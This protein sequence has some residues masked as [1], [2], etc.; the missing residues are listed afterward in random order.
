MPDG[1]PQLCPPVLLVGMLENRIP[2]GPWGM[3]AHSRAW[4][5]AG[6]GFQRSVGGKEGKGGCKLGEKVRHAINMWHPRKEMSVCGSI[7]TPVPEMG[8]EMVVIW[9][10]KSGR[11]GTR[12]TAEGGGLPEFG[13]S[14]HGCHVAQVVIWDAIA[15][16]RGWGTRQSRVAQ[17]L[18]APKGL[19]MLSDGGRTGLELSVSSCS[20]PRTILSPF[21]SEDG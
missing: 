3:S 10:I 6:G 9:G 12:A 7:D 15:A 1:H 20:P 11:I 18:R 8:R 2:A 21:I 19:L 13:G 16:E 5:K 17:G 4:E 14:K